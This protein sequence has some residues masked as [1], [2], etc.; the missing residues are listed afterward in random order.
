M[1]HLANGAAEAEYDYV[2]EYVR[3][4]VS[5]EYKFVGFTNGQYGCQ[6]DDRPDV[7]IQHHIVRLRLVTG[8]HS[9]L[10]DTGNAI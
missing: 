3:M 1:T 2:D 8:P 10:G 7:Y 5:E 6:I 9:G 4:A